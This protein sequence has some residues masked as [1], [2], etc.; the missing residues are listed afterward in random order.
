MRRSRH[1]HSLPVRL[2]RARR[3]LSSS[4]SKSSLT[5]TRSK[6]SPPICPGQRAWTASTRPGALGGPCGLHYIRWP[7]ARFSV[8]HAAQRKE[9]PSCEAG[10]KSREERAKGGIMRPRT[11]HRIMR[12]V[13]RRVTWITRAIS[14]AAKCESRHSRA[15]SASPLSAKSRSW[16]TANRKGQ[17]YKSLTTSA[18][19][20]KFMPFY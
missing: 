5:K 12:R 2:G 4:S 15:I 13:C 18:A 3:P 6:E 1:R 9:R 16:K 19:N 7:S 11:E 10:L 17:A 20:D 8:R 14:M